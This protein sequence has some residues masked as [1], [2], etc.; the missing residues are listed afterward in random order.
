MERIDLIKAVRD[1]LVKAGFYVS[2][3]YP[4]RL[5]G[6]DL[7]AR[8][9]D[10][11]LI[12]KILSNIDALN[13][14]TADEIVKLSHLLK[15]TPLLIG[16]KT[17]LTDLE[18]N[19]V[20]YRFSIKAITLKT[21]S[22]HLLEGVPVTIYAAPGGLYVDL[23]E[24]KL[25]LLRIKKGLS[26][27]ALARY[28][29]IS[30]R[31]AQLYEKGEMNARV[32]I[33]SRIEEL[34]ETSAAVPIDIIGPQVTTEDENLDISNRCTTTYEGFQREV[35]S[36]IERIGYKIIPL[37]RCPF[38]AVSKQ[39]ENVLLTCVDKNNKKLFIKAQIIS[40]ISR[41]TEKYA[42]II[43]DRETYKTNVEG[44]P[45]LCKKELEKIKDPDEVIKFIIE[46]I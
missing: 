23:D 35:F 30:R 41:V 29:N 3:L 26:L 28:I 17:G 46:R 1:V 9:D 24:E 36:I 21:L 38:E 14:D 16:E 2:E 40:S 8:R 27:G 10:N 43:T 37:E 44:T 18:D 5:Q 31:T 42:M 33:A 25:R 39:K 19:V 20:Y 32:E 12:V 6:F 22:D 34:L 7:I 45:I 15:A 13:Q 11:L 4:I